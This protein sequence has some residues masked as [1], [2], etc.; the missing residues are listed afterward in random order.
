MMPVDEA[1]EFIDTV[2]NGRGAPRWVPDRH[3]VM[4]SA[5]VLCFRWTP[6]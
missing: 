3:A 5:V 6:M 2:W 1:L 4:E